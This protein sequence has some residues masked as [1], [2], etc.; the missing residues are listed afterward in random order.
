MNSSML[1]DRQ[2]FVVFQWKNMSIERNHDEYFSKML[3]YIREY[4]IDHYD[5]AQN[6]FPMLNQNK[7][8]DHQFESL[9]FPSHVSIILP[10]LLFH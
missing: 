6:Y 10:L 9:I 3:I 2:F 1:F 7:D 8:N 4:S 5:W